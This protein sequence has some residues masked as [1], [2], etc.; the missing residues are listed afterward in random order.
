MTESA[1]WPIGVGLSML[2]AVDSTNAEARRRA[3]AGEV[4]PLWIVADRQLEGRGRRGRT[5]RSDA[6]DLTAT[7]LISPASLRPE[8]TLSEIGTLSFVAGLAVADMIDALAPRAGATLKWPNDVL[9]RDRKIAGI[10]LESE[11][12]GEAAWLA[13]GVGVN[14]AVAPAP[15]AVEP[16]AVA[17][18]ALAEVASGAVDRDAALR[19]LAFAMAARL[20]DWAEQGFAAAR[21][22]WLARAA[23]LGETIVA[24]LPQE[25]ASGRF[26]DVDDTGALVLTTPNGTR[27]IAAADVFFP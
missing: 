16:G 15:E 21:Q 20:A 25:T 4:G 19:G 12:A 6:Q 11:G 5:W 13:I 9:V 14:I 18:I 27:R 24:R 26:V 2:E 22:A 23:R 3:R 10:L 1:S 7:L 8:T 17:P